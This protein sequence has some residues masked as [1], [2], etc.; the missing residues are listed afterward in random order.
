M[1]N[2]FGRAPREADTSQEPVL[3]AKLQREREDNERFLQQLY[4]NAA[5]RP[6]H[7]AHAVSKP[8]HAPAPSPPP[9]A[10]IELLDVAR[11]L[12]QGRDDVES[13]VVRVLIARALELLS[14]RDQSA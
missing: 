2:P 3:D 6:G 11:E 10:A 1:K 13:R 4:A 12:L 14:E 7:P 9:T 8:E 5:P